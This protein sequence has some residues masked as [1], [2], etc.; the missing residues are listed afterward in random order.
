MAK[1]EQ[2]EVL[3]SMDD[4]S[5]ARIPQTPGLKSK[6]AGHVACSQQS[7]AEVKDPAVG[8]EVCLPE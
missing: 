3:A 6:D 7:W 5:D 8:L 2:M 1:I 4:R